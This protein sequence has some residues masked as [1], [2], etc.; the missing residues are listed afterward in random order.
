VAAVGILPR[1]SA[2]EQTFGYGGKA[3]TKDPPP[4]AKVIPLRE[5]PDLT[6]EER[7][8]TTYMCEF[9]SGVDAQEA[10]AE[11]ATG[12]PL[13]YVP[14]ESRFIRWQLFGWHVRRKL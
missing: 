1:A 7:F 9:S 11:R 12:L 3:V 14:A 2:Q 8:K 13:R 4:C 5:A 10:V 6:P